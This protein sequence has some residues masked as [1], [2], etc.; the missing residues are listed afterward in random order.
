MSMVSAI[1][2]IKTLVLFFTKATNIP[3]RASKKLIEHQ[4]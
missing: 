2:K 4:I 3:Q 1:V